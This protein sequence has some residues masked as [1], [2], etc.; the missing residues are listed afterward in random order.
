MVFLVFFIAHSLF[1]YLGIF[2]SMGLKRVLIGVMPAIAIIALQGYNW[3]SEMTMKSPVILKRSILSLI[4]IFVLVFPFIPNPA[5]IHPQR[6]LCLSQNQKVATG[7]VKLINDSLKI[8]GR[9][10]YAA[11]SLGALLQIDPFDSTQF[12]ALTTENINN[13]RKGDLI[14]WDDWFA[15]VENQIIR[16]ML[17]NNIKLRS[18][19]VFKGHDGAREIIYAMYEKR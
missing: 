8:H 11:P 9:Y 10:L 18:L 15:V 2:N 17:D 14:I 3:I 5:A 7:M 4:I 16:N 6:D 1:W 19:K 13:L 12:M